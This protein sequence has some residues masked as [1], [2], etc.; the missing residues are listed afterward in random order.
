MD[1]C[2]F[3]QIVAGNIPSFKIYQDE[4]VY[5]F[6]DINPLQEGHTLLIPKAHYENIWEIPPEQLKAIAAASQKVSVALQTALKPDG[7]CVM[8]LNGRGVHQIVMHY[9][10]HLIPKNAESPEFKLTSWDLVPGDMD[11]IK[12]VSEKVASCLKE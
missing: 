11:Q 8:Q 10:M 5:A 1:E 3:C 2:I 7:L 4:T 9:H 12:A 6:A